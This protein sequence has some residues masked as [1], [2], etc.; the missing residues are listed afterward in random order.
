MNYKDIFSNIYDNHGFGS[1]E[2]RSGPG[3]TLDETQK[4]RESIKKIIKDKNI[5]SVVD[6]PCGDFN[7]MKEI[8]FN[9]ESYIGGD[10]VK[11]AIEENNERYSNSRIKILD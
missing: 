10:I 4:L 1:L 3:S 2:S 7:W 5:K 8:V 9:F 6:I 11:K